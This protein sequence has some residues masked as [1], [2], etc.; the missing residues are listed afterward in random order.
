MNARPTAVALSLVSLAAWAIFLGVLTNRPELWVAALPLLAPLLVWSGEADPGSWAVALEVSADR[1]LEGDRMVVTITLSAKTRLPLIEV[2]APLPSG[3]ELASGHPRA[4]FSLA[5]GEQAGWQYEV[6][7]PQRGRFSFGTL[8]VRVLDR[9]GLSVTEKTQVEQRTIS[10]YPRPVPLHRL[11]RPQRTQTSFGNY[12]APQLGDGIEPGDIRP[13]APG[14]RVRRVN[15]R[16][17][18][19]RG[20]LYVTQFHQERNADVVLLLD[21]TTDSGMHPDSIIDH[22]VRAACRIAAAYLARKDRVG[23]IEYGGFLRTIRPG[24]G[25]AH[26]ERVIDAL[27]PADVIFSYVG[28]DLDLLPT[29]VLPS[30][31]LIIA[32]SP[33]LDGRFVRALADLAARGFDLVVIVVSPM[34]PTRRALPPSRLVELACRFWALERK[35]RLDALRRR[36]LTVL[37]WSPDEPLDVVVARV[38]PRRP[39]RLAAV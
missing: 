9:W 39:A 12:V 19:R 1:L 6:R 18:T 28:R 32:L 24:S 22:A 7:C 2:V 37:E 16:A 35:V 27:L 21:T 17:S 31:A 33:L 8:R 5:A 25:R 4:I 36:G 10:V 34:E 14:D 15:W 26:Y 23:L 3:L 11:P 30:N 29:G 38:P 13:F 20:Q